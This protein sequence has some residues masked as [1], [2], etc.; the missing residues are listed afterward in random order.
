MTS[1]SQVAQ[2]EDPFEPL[3]LP[4]IEPLASNEERWG[5]STAVYGASVLAATYCGFKTVP[6]TARGQWMHGWHPRYQEKLH[7]DLILGYITNPLDHFWV[8]RK[9]EEEFLRDYGYRNVLAVGLP[10]VYLPPSD[11]RRRPGSLLVMP[12]HSTDYTTHSW[13][14]D[15]Y[16]DAIA[17]IRGYFS[18]VVVCVHANC[19]KRGYWIDSF[20]QRGFSVV[21]GA[22]HYD[23]NALKRIQILMS[24][25]EYMTT[26]GFGSHLVYA[27]YF[28]AKPSVYG[29]FAELLAEDFKG[30]VLFRHHHKMLERRIQSTLLETLR[31]NLPALCCHPLDA[32]ADVEWACLEL[33]ASHKVAPRHM[34]SLFGWSA[35]ERMRRALTATIPAPIK[36]CARLL[37]KPAYRASDRLLKEENRLL[38]MARHQPASTSLLGPTLK[39]Q[40]GPQFV[41]N[42][43]LLFDQ[44]LY[45]FVAEGDAPRV[46][47]CGAGIGLSVL[48]FKKLYPESQITAFEP[49]PEVFEL[50]KSNCAAWGANDVRLIP[51]AVWNCETTITFSRDVYSVGRI[52]D[53]AIGD[54]I[55]RVRA[56]RLRDHLTGPADLL[57]LNIEG[58]E[59]DVL[60]DCA[61]L[62]EQVQNLI[63]DYHSLVE[64]PQRLDTLMGILTKAGFRM[65]IRATSASPSPLLYRGVPRGIDCK[66]H[67]FAF[68]M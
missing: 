46:F 19:W 18:E 8:S 33:G 5:G 47:D 32:K 31:Q 29:P 11:V 22:A 21:P 57:R 61:D 3:R 50:L 34:R 4:E 42:K 35:P 48:Y 14:F 64:R 13:R 9:D 28:G 58:A 2:T 54:D 36:H 56:C 17:A 12:A 16:A 37:V 44:E 38:A 60:L 52:A 66:L 15:E 68:R 7:P 6:T 67:I 25:C 23:R 27:A 24:R 59:V 30:D 55:L 10:V 49:D 40:D 65:H 20:R 63:V 51:A 39:I 62:L 1:M 41:E 26:N 43:R 53:R 45:R